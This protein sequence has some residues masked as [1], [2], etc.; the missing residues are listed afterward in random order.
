MRA[1]GDCVAEPE[2]SRKA[3]LLSFTTLSG[4]QLLAFHKATTRLQPV[5]LYEDV[6][7]P[8]LRAGVM[9]KIS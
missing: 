7:E 2:V 4:E 6:I 8:G 1:Q 9:T 3:L 5:A